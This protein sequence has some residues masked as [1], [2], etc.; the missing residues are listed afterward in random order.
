MAVNASQFG[1]NYHHKEVM[2]NI[3]IPGISVDAII[4]LTF[5]AVSE[6]YAGQFVS[7]AVTE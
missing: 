1:T 6:S 7:R 4:S 5:H 2:K 3:T